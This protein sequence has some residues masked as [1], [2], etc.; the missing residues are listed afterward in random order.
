MAQM[1]GCSAQDS[2]Q[3]NGSGYS[4]AVLVHFSS[5]QSLQQQQLR[6]VADANMGGYTIR[7]YSDDIP[8]QFNVGDRVFVW[9]KSNRSTGLATI[10]QTP[11][12]LPPDSPFAGRYLAR[13]DVDSTLTAHV[14]PERLYPV[15][16]EP[17]Q[18]LVCYHTDDYRRL[19][20]S[21]VR[22]DSNAQSVSDLYSA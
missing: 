8:R 14:R 7:L 4:P 1:S 20:R 17:Q 21:Q 2:A 13:Y 12:D 6:I 9:L 15:Y 3:L 10:V 11:D 22:P 16:T 19:A 5:A 18:M